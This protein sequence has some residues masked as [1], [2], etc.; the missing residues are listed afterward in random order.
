[1]INKLKQVKLNSIFFSWLISYGSVLL[2]PLIISSVVY[3]ESAR[4][5][6]RE[7]N[8]VNSAMLKQVQQAVDSRLDE[9]RSIS[10]QTLANPDVKALQN[11]GRTLENFQ[12][13]NIVRITQSFSSYRRLNG[14]IDDIYLY[15]KN[16]DTVLTSSN[17]IASEL[18]FD[19]LLQYQG[20]S[21]PEWLTA[22][23]GFHT[24]HFMP[25]GR[26]TRPNPPNMKLALLQSAPPERPEDAFATLAIT[27]NG[28]RLREVLQNSN[29]VNQGQVLLIDR[30]DNVYAT[31]RAKEL[32][33]PGYQKLK[34]NTG[35]IR[36]TL[37]GE[38]VVISHLSSEVTDLKY[39]SVI[40]ERVF[41]QKMSYIRNLALLSFLFCLA[42][43][44]M[45]A[46]FFLKR[47]YNPISNLVQILGQKAGI[48]FDRG[49]NEYR[50]IQV[51]LSKIFKEKDQADQELH[52]H[53]TEIR[54]NYL[55]RLLKGQLE[56]KLGME[57][58]LSSYEI[59]FSSDYFGV[60]IFYI[61]DSTKL[62]ASET[63]V[64][65]L[66]QS[67]LARL[68]LSDVIE[69]L[70]GASSR[71]YVVEIDEVTLACLVNFNQLN[72]A[73]DEMR[74][75]A[76]QAQRIIEEQ[77]QIYC[78]VALSSIHQLVPGIVA[79]YHEALEVM[80]Y[81]MVV[82]NNKIISQDDIKEPQEAKHSYYYPLD[83]E[84]QLVNC[85]KIGDL[86]RAKAIID[87]VFKHNFVAKSISVPMT[88][89]LMF[90]MVSTVVKAVNEMG[91]SGEGNYLEELKI[92]ERLLGCDTAAELR[93][94]LEE[95]LTSICSDLQQ[96]KKHHQDLVTKIVSFIRSNYA[97]ENLN[98]SMIGDHFGLTPA[99]IS[100][101]FKRGTGEGL[102]AYITKIR[103][104]Q[105]KLLLKENK[106]NL[107]EIARKVGFINSHV[108][109]RTFK[110]I[111]GITPGKYKEI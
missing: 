26:Q 21:Y 76:S 17:H 37:H 63:K 28:I 96:K 47:N 85:I 71:N 6:R 35:I 58:L 106:L 59:Q 14:F 25:L 54:A 87:T 103:I 10:L 67:R 19:Y 92:I 88:K 9:I 98:I 86:D 102:L 11:A 8:R 83:Q 4:V 52:S 81:K 51:T 104:E 77:L 62:L 24:N 60:I 15:L 46:Y 34:G 64:S 33:S 49:T 40:P 73:K 91:N 97:D 56:S 30:F 53:R 29:P 95:I 39:V 108:L 36:G 48:A 5:F 55:R 93:A 65:G 94:E 42:L 2:V 105:A 61:E 111:E 12:R 22:L 101:I 80:E 3:L 78:T 72:G 68:I 1:M 89:C 41:W 18:A 23:R 74:R 45:V 50:F 32:T 31:T 20:I 16:S 43:G 110:K 107:N 70:A 13:S 109:I 27:L 38:R 7:V 82:G 75:I 100:A 57:E 79:A 84:Y 90:N 66:E 69:E 99:Y 44:G